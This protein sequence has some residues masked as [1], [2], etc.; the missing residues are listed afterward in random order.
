[1]ATMFLL[2]FESW[3]NRRERLEPKAKELEEYFKYTGLPAEAEELLRSSTAADV[4]GPLIVTS[5]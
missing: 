5:V 3:Q 1:M 4:Q 2:D